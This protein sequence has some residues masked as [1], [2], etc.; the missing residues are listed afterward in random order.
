MNKL[1]L[2]YFIFSLSILY[3]NENASIAELSRKL[4]LVI[5]KLDMLE[6]RVSKIESDNTQVRKE[7]REVAKATKDVR[8]SNNS[9]PQDQIEKKSFLQKL[10]NQIKTQQTLE[11]GP[12]TNKDTWQKIRRNL[13]AF[14]VRKLLGAPTKIKKSINPRIDQ[15]YQYIGD[16][17][18]DGILNQGYVNFYR[19]RVTSFT[20]PFED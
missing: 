16:L 19:D 4:E 15:I 10:G 13:T 18:S 5:E 12:W 3:G 1:I 9:L 14:Q 6:A 2:T 11:D 17:D 20:S 8:E 7:V